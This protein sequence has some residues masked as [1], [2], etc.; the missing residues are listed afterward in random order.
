MSKNA[1]SFNKAF[2]KIF[3]TFLDEYL[4]KSNAFNHKAPPTPNKDASLTYDNFLQAK[5]SQRPNQVTS[6]RDAYSRQYLMLPSAYGP[7]IIWTTSLIRAV[8]KDSSL[9]WSVHPTLVER[10]SAM[11]KNNADAEKV[12][13]LLKNKRTDANII[14]NLILGDVFNA[15]MIQAIGEDVALGGQIGKDGLIVLP[16]APKATPKE[17]VASA[18]EE[19]AEVPAAEAIQEEIR[20]EVLGEK[21]A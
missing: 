5:A 14:L 10:V 13:R 8:N 15:L 16:K 1:H 2:V 17:E 19:V 21:A 9:G 3:T 12:L 18:P 7:V 20:E 6:G 11:A 4:N